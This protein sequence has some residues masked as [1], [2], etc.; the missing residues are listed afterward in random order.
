MLQENVLYHSGA[1]W[2]SYQ[3]PLGRRG[4]A[5][6]WSYQLPPGRRRGKP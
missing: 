5:R 2:W 4:G 1:R 6:W 3:L